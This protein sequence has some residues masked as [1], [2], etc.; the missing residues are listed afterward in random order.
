MENV[1][2]FHLI[3]FTIKHAHMHAHT[4]R[5]TY[6]CIRT[7]LVAAVVVMSSG[8]LGGCLEAYNRC[9]R[10]REQGAAALYRLYRLEDKQRSSMDH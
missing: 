1:L 6:T 9:C 4:Q 3:T 8:M 2:C 7:D 5:H 10:G